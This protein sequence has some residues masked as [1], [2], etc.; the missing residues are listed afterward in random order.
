MYEYVI[1]SGNL[2]IWFFEVEEKWRTKVKKI[3]NTYKYI[4]TP[5]YRI[6][7]PNKKIRA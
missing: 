5:Y 6:A 7:S 1:Y 3:N 2:Y 4:I